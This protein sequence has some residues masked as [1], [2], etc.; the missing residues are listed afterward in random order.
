MTYSPLPTI[1]ELEE[2]Y[3]YSVI[4]G[5]LYYKVNAG[6]KGTGAIAGSKHST[7]YIVVKFKGKAYRAHRLIWKLV[8]GEDP[9][10][11]IDHK[12]NIRDNNA[13]HN[14]R[15]A[16]T[17]QNQSNSLMRC[18]NTAGY[19]GVFK[20]PSGKYQ[21]TIKYQSKSIHLGTYDT[22]EDAHAAY[23]AK[24][25]ELFGEFANVG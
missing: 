12:D 21:A 25:T 17:S 6:R 8:T 9:P 5:E 20:R 13:W 2:R 10:C 4:T 23:V 18:D 14:L 24:A 11:D 15:L 16:T 19:K 7:G 3:F 22:A 1:E